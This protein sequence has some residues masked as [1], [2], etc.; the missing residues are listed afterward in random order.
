MV[1]VHPT[2]FLHE[3]HYIALAFYGK[4]GYRGVQ[5]SHPLAAGMVMIILILP[6][7]KAR[8]EA[9]CSLW[10]PS[11]SPSLSLLF[12][13]Q[14]LGFRSL[15]LFSC[16]DQGYSNILPCTEPCLYLPWDAFVIY[17]PLFFFSDSTHFCLRNCG[18]S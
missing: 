5:L 3:L 13:I 7:E 1:G 18:F 2:F 12:P 9:G 14:M 16:S 4:E 11:T 6:E 17:L 10:K 8:P 15:L